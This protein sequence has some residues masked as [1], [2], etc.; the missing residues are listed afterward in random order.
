MFDAVFFD[1]DGTLIDT[2]I[3]WVEA[4]ECALRDAGLDPRYE[5]V[6]ADVYGIS[7]QDVE[8]N[9]KRRHPGMTWDLPGI[10]AHFHRLRE[11][12]HLPIEGSVRLLREL[13]AEYPVAIVS[14]SSAGDV[15]NGI[16]E[17]GVGDCL[18]FALDNSC[19]SPGKPDPACYR[20]AAE[21]LGVAPER[22]LVFE[23]SRVG[24]GAAKGAGMH[25]VALARADR[26]GQ[27]LSLA[28]WVLDDLAHFS[29]DAYQARRPVNR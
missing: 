29:V 14:G 4:T 28:D 27:D 19:Y 21:R 15:R 12:R 6:L 5:D 7:W 8:V 22:C 9:C 25:C 11:G 23:D 13:A 20:M 18:V 2:E 3:L 26:P 17:A 24:V 10:K 1:L 16:V